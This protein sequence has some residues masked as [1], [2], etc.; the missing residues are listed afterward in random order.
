MVKHKE[1]REEKEYGTNEYQY[2]NV[3]VSIIAYID[4]E[5]IKSIRE[6]S[7]KYS[8]ESLPG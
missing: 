2:K 6:K 1:E 3:K 5:E 7:F 4:Q 8:T